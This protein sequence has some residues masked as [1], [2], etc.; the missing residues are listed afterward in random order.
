MHFLTLFSEL[1]KVYF[2]ELTIFESLFLVKFQASTLDESFAH[3][4]V[5]FHARALVKTLMALVLS[6]RY[7]ICLLQP[8]LDLQL[9]KKSLRPPL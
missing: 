1:Y 3:L 7:A 8:T 4:L 6:T 2:A 5:K 9:S